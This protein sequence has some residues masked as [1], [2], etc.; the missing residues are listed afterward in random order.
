MPTNFAFSPLNFSTSHLPN[1]SSGKL[2]WLLLAVLMLS[3][4]SEAFA[5]GNAEGRGPNEA[6]PTGLG[7]AISVTPY[8]STLSDESLQ[9]YTLSVGLTYDFNSR[10]SLRALFFTGEEVVASDPSRPVSG[11]LLMGA[12]SIGAVYHFAYVG[13]FRFYGG[14]GIDLQTI[15]NSAQKGYNGNGFQLSA[16]TDYL[17]DRNISLSGG[18]LFKRCYYRSFVNK[19]NWSALNPRFNDSWIG[20]TLAVNVHFD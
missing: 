14:G 9:N 10:L 18:L 6:F 12:G 5:K 1:F 11:K 7:L 19:G 2:Q 13:R 3:M 20:L 17:L 8:Y 16:G 15:L 4:S